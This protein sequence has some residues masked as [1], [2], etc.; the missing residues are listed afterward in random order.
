MTHPVLVA[1]DGSVRAGG[2][3]LAAATIAEAFH[4]TLHLLRV[5]SIPPEFPPAAACGARGDPLPA[6]LE[7]EALEAMRLLVRAEPRAHSS[8]MLVR[9]GAQPWRAILDVADE[10]EADLIV[11]GSHGYHAIDRLLGTTAGRVAN[12][13]RRN[14]LVVHD[15]EARVTKVAQKG[16]YRSSGVG[17]RSPRPERRHKG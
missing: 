8:L 1:V 12:M 9:Q 13:A 14:V 6:F 3:L 7:H 16:P 15:G 11:R 5:I 4:S 2:V 10:I 17:A